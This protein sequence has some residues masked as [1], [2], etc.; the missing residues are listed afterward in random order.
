MWNIN[1][2][3]SKIKAFID[4][5]KA[6]MC[7]NLISLR[8]NLTSLMVQRN[9]SAATKGLNTAIEQMT[10][11]YKLN[12]A[13]DNPANY[14]M[15]KNMETKL[16][17][18]EVASENISMGYDML[19]TADSN[20]SLIGNHLI[21]IR[22]LLEQASNGTYGEESIKAIKAEVAAR[23]DEINRI[24]F[25]AKYNDI[26]LFGEYDSDG[27][28]ISKDINLQVGI[29]S[30]ES[31]KIPVNMTMDLSR[32]SDIEDWDITDSSCLNKLDLII[33]NVS[34]YQVK[35]GASQNRLECALELAEVNSSRLA[36]SISTIKDADIAKVSSNYIKYQILQQSCATLLATANQ[37]PSIALQLI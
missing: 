8:T 14:S 27:N 21:R 15:M 30:S 28:L 7:V 22:D 32:V 34:D 11:G 29:D 35:I 37:M 19:E 23:V 9:L 25:N 24:K 16:R 10:T 17:A 13:K 6:R 20:A 31:S 5:F 26:K 3:N 36:S 2:I 18:W 1:K 4:I 12:H 33:D